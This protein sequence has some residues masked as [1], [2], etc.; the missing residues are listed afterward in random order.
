MIRYVAL[1]RRQIEAT[2]GSR[3]AVLVS[4]DAARV[5]W[6]L[7]ARAGVTRPGTLR[8]RAPL[9]PGRFTLTV[10]ANG[11]SARAAVFVRSPTP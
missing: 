6:K 11:R 8:L 4:S 9:Q 2:P 5:T 10:T 7:G 1:G 3:I